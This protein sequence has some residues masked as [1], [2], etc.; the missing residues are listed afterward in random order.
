MKPV[1][2]VDD[3]SLIL[4][5]VKIV[6]QRRGYEVV[7]APSGMDCLEHL[8]QG[9]R[10][11]ILMDIMMPG[12]DGWQT[13]RALVNEQLQAGN[14]ICMLTAKSSVGAEANGLEEFVFDYL[15]KPFGERALLDMVENAIA[16]L[17]V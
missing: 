5:T 14:M 17:P 6:L 9:F 15:T 2:I 7:Q 4:N 16:F 12:L 13:I 8:R 11:V 1:M 3:D 10:G